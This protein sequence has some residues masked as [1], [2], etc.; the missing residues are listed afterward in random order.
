MMKTDP[1]LSETLLDI[2]SEIDM[3]NRKAK[4]AAIVQIVQLMTH[5]GIEVGDLKGTECGVPVRRAKAKYLNPQTGQTWAGR[6]R[7]PKWLVGR[8][9]E[10][11]RIAYQADQSTDDPAGVGPE[12]E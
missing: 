9:I 5:F 10:A 8:D 6:G 3:L 2:Q 12:A 4:A 1:Q 7:V 11:Y